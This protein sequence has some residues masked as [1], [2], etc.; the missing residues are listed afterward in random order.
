[1]RR[2]KKTQ[3]TSN[4]VRGLVIAGLAIVAVGSGKLKTYIDWETIGQKTQIRLPD[5]SIPSTP[6]PAGLEIPAMTN[7]KQGQIICHTGYTLAYDAQNK[8]PQWV[9]WELTKAET[10]GKE[11]RNDKF[12]ED[13]QVRGVKVTNNDYAGSGYDRGHMAPAGDMKW[14]AQAMEESFYMT[15]MCPQLHSLNAGDWNELENR[16]REWAKK[17]NKVY[18]VCGPIYREQRKAKYIG[19]N[20]IRVPD[21]FYKVVLIY[22]KQ[23]TVALGFLFE[24]KKGQKPLKEYL[25]T[26]DHIE[27]ITGLDF[28]PALPDDLEKRLEAEHHNKLP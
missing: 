26:V 13:P 2:K 8:T 19:K 1:M 9:A 11:K 5:T 23:K 24:H 4:F 3:K 18:I 16:C 15:N 22:E 10:Q 14:N 21:E 25:T 12:Q 7:G 20:R 6:T 17:Y 27:N 28:F